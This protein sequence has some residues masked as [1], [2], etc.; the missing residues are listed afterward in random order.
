LEQHILVTLR[1]HVH[2][3]SASKET[4]VVST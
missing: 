2:C 1:T 4:A 3:G